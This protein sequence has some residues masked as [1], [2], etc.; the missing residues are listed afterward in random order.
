MPAHKQTIEQEVRTWF[1]EPDRAS[2]AVLE[3]IARHI[4]GKQKAKRR[5]FLRISSICE[6]TRY[7]PITVKRALKKLS[8][9]GYLIIYEDPGF[10]SVY[11]IPPLWDY[12]LRVQWLQHCPV[13]VDIPEL[14]RKGQQYRR[15]LGDYAPRMGTGDYFTISDLIASE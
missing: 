4:F 3:C 1:T 2:A 14:S 5:A 9:Q 10:H 6:E 15:R 12:K 7:E 13:W 11:I 8:Q